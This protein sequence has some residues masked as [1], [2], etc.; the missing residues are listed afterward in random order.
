M[1]KLFI[2][3]FAVVILFSCKTRVPP[4]HWGVLMENFG[5]NGKSDYSLVSGKVSDWQAHQKLFEVPAWEQRANFEFPMHL[6]AADKTEFTSTPSYS[7][8]IPKDR[9]IDVVFYNAHLDSAASFMRALENN[10]LETRIYDIGKDISRKYG[11]D[12]LMSIGGG[13]KYENEVRALV[14]K[15]FDS[16]GVKLITF[17]FPLVPTEKVKERIDTRNEVNT[18]LS[19]LDQKIMEQMR[20]NRLDSLKMV[21]NIL[22]S[23]G[24]TTQILTRDFID[25]WDGKTQLFFLPS[26]VVLT[27]PIQ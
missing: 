20:Q 19:V 4:N 8:L 26:G 11:I 13:M 5:K 15:A 24:L 9:A 3:L 18:N 27:K 10:V 1:K 22:I 6:E 2:F 23:R 21:N 16:I 12:T 7:Y 14:Q 25:K 17:T